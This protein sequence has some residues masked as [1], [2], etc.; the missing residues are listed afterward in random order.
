MLIFVIF[1][2]NENNTFIKKGYIKLF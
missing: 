2:T 1:A